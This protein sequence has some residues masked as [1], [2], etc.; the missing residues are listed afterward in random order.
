MIETYD[1][2]RDLALALNLPRVEETTAWGRPIVKAHGKM[3]VWWSP[4]V[5]AAVFNC[6]FDEREMLLAADPDTFLLH[7]H[8][9]KY[10]YVLVRAGRLDPAWARARLTAQ[11]RAMAPKRW[12]R[13]WDATHGRG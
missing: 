5:D 9:A 3:W 13:D 4:Y 2:L 8:Y 11:W 7:P 6:G 12:L 1:Q 10:P